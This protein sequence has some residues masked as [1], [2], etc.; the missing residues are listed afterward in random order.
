MGS[1]C[2]TFE[3]DGRAP[4]WCWHIWVRMGGEGWVAAKPCD[5]SAWAVAFWSR[6]GLSLAM[7]GMLWGVVADVAGC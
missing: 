7:V 3:A 5:V 2:A 6:V 1:S 4:Y